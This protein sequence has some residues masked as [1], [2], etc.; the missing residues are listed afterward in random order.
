MLSGQLPQWIVYKRNLTHDA[1]LL[2][3][4]PVCKHVFA[5][6]ALALC[7]DHFQSLSPCNSTSEPRQWGTS[8]RRFVPVFAVPCQSA[9]M[10]SSSLA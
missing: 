1:G 2:D 5:Q 6:M 8:K 10:V 9:G 3:S 7:P 4:C